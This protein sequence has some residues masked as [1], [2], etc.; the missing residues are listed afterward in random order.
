MPRQYVDL[1]ASPQSLPRARAFLCRRYKK[2]PRSGF[3][4]AAHHSLNPQPI[5]ISF[6]NRSR[7]HAGG[8]D[9]VQRPPI[10]SQSSHIKG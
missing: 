9:T 6:N 7:L 2:T 3:G 1:W 5:S 4:K 8:R 10:G